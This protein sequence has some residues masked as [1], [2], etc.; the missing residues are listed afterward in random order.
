VILSVL[1]AVLV[2]KYDLLD[3]AR[4]LVT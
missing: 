1:A 4:N 2:A 3:H